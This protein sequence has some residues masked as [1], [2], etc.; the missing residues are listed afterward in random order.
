M[1]GTE[2]DMKPASQISLPLKK[3]ILNQLPNLEHIW[4]LNP[5]EILILQEFQEVCI[6]NCQS[7][8]S[9]FPTSVASHLAMLDVR[10]CATLEEIFVENEAVMKGETKQFNFHCLTTLTL[11]E[12]PEL[13]SCLAWSIK[14]ILAKTI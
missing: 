7:L 2:V 3:L 5:D 10:S 13:K 14:Q 11:W 1:E 4:N 6:S 9:L 8:K 12:L